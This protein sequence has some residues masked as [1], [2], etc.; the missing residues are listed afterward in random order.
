MQ[1]LAVHPR[2]GRNPVL[3]LAAADRILSAER[4][5]LA[6]AIDPLRAERRAGSV[7][8]S[9]SD[10]VDAD[11]GRRWF[12]AVADRAQSTAT[13][14]R[15]RRH[16]GRS[17]RGRCLVVHRQLQEHLRIGIPAARQ[18][19][20]A[21]GRHPLYAGLRLSTKRNRER[22]SLRR[23][24]RS[25]RALGLLEFVPLQLQQVESVARIA[26]IAVRRKERAFKNTGKK[27][28]KRTKKRRGSG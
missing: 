8:A 19:R 10:G 1:L 14:C 5:M 9:G 26:S 17:H 20:R 15:E 7:A 28:E 16:D 6:H 18:R 3:R 23:R 27:N 4:G 24:E 13:R 25:I 21:F 11:G 22:V 2:Q 12:T